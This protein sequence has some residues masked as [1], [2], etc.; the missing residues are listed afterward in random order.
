V[1]PPSSYAWW[2]PFLIIAMVIGAIAAFF[3]L[4]ATL[5]KSV[6]LW[7]EHDRWQADIRESEARR[8]ARKR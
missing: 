6:D 7:Q 1:M 5:F 4:I 3:T 8:R 2:M